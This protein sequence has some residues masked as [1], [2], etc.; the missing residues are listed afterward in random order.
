MSSI[1][2]RTIPRMRV[3][4]FSDYMASKASILSR[5]TKSNFVTLLMDADSAEA[6]DHSGNLQFMASDSRDVQFSVI[7]ET[8]RN[9]YNYLLSRKDDK[10]YNRSRQH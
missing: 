4:I 1:R 3:K 2:A 8:H 7:A 6:T 5:R 9:L 10:N